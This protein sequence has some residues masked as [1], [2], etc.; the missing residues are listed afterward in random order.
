MYGEPID[1]CWSVAIRG[2][3]GSYNNSS[4]ISLFLSECSYPG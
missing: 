1:S 3:R 2:E 4:T